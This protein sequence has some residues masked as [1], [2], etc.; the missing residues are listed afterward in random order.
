[1]TTNIVAIA[2]IMKVSAALGLLLS[3]WP[4]ILAFLNWTLFIL[5]VSLALSHVKTRG[6]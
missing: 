1:M 3:N 2:F 5:V 4:F 6:Q